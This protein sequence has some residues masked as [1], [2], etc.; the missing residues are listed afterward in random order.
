[1]VIEHFVVRYGLFHPWKTQY[2]SGLGEQNEANFKSAENQIENEQTKAIKEFTPNN[3]FNA[4]KSGFYYRS[5]INHACILKQ[6]MQK[7][8]RHLKNG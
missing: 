7:A 3:I 8:V 5:L 2:I 6:A 1:M 4:D